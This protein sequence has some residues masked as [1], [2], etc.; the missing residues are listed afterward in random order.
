MHILPVFG[1]AVDLLAY[2]L[3]KSCDILSNIPEIQL[4]QNFTLKNSMVKDIAEVKIQGHIFDLVSNHCT[5][6]LFPV[7]QIHHFMAKM[8]FKAK[9]NDL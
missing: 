3:I 6:F 7:N 9:V 8:T 4:F 1:I 5:S 2:V